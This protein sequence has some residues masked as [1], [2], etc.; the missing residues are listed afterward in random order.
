MISWRTSSYS[1]YEEN[2]C[3]EVGTE[4]GLVRIR[5][6]KQA[7]A[8]EKTRPV[9]VFRTATFRRFLAHLRK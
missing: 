8:A 5:D 7:G 1:H 6:T 3:V 2:A 4:P 9:L